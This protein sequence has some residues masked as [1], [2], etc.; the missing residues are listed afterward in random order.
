MQPEGV[1]RLTTALLSDRDTARLPRAE[2]V[3]H[4]DL[5]Q[6]EDVDHGLE[7]ADIGRADPLEPDHVAVALATGRGITWLSR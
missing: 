5:S 7:Q 4:L 1:R 6:Y 3:G 2:S